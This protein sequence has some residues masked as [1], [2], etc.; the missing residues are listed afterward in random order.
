MSDSSQPAT[1]W[2]GLAATF[3]AGML[4]T[5]LFIM[6]AEFG[7]DPSGIGA[8]LGLTNLADTAAREPVPLA[9][10]GEFPAIVQ[11]FDENQPPVIGLPFANNAFDIDLQS[12]DIT[13]EL[14]AGE[15][16]EYKAIMNQGDMLVYS[17]SSDAQQIYSDFHADPS[18]NV[19]AYPPGYFVRYHESDEAGAKGGLV[20]P[21]TGNH[22]WYWLNYNEVPVTIQL[23]VRGYYT[24]IHELGRSI[25]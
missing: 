13:I 17:W 9:M 6:P 20:A 2:K 15:Q 3:L 18:E 23:K 11:D 12:D 1:L 8:L 25:Q 24:E 10:Q 4:A 16:V 14:E 5:I 7:K 22:G 21:F 19:E